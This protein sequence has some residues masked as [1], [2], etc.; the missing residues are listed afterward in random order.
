[1][2]ETGADKCVVLDVA[3]K[4]DQVKS[5]NNWLL[6]INDERIIPFGA[7]HPDYPDYKNEIKRL[8]DH[9]IKGVKFQSTWQNCFADDDR[10]LRI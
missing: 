1:M 2:E 9:G 10:M 3:L 8:K 7:M 6:N 5:I 4:P